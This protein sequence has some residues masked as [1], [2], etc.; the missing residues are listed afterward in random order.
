MMSAA[1][2]AKRPHSTELLQHDKATPYSFFFFFLFLAFKYIHEQERKKR[3]EKK[4]GGER[5]R[6]PKWKDPA[7]IACY[8]SASVFGTRNNCN[9]L[10]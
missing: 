4:R 9:T 5:K 7:A 6:P 3:G 10:Q 2:A 1:V 8:W